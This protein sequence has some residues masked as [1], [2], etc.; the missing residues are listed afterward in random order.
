[1]EANTGNSRGK[2]AKSDCSAPGELGV[3][4]GRQIL[5]NALVLPISVRGDQRKKIVTDIRCFE[6]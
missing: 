1:M 4:A 2:R 6:S 3:S 5:Q